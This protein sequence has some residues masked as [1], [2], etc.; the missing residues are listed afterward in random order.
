MHLGPDAYWLVQSIIF[1]L[2]LC[3]QAR[4][5]ERY[6]QVSCFFVAFISGFLFFLLTKIE[7]I[8]DAFLWASASCIYVWPMLYFLLFLYLNCDA[9]NKLKRYFAL[10]CLF[11][12]SSA[13]EPYA[14]LSLTYCLTYY[15]KKKYKEVSNINQFNFLRNC[16][17]IKKKENLSL[18]ICIAGAIFEIFAPG[19]FKRAE[20]MHNVLPSS[21]EDFYNLFYYGVKWCDY[22]LPQVYPWWLLILTIILAITTILLDTINKA[23]LPGEY[24]CLILSW[25]P[26]FV[27]LF[28]PASQSP[29]AIAPIF[30]FIPFIIVP[31]LVKTYQKIGDKLLLVLAISIFV[32]L[33]V[34]YWPIVKG[35]KENYVI[36][37]LNHRILLS[38]PDGDVQQINLFKLRNDLYANCMPY[39]DQWKYIERF[40]KRYYDL[41]MNV[42][43]TYQNYKE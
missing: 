30:I 20:A 16:C 42:S 32:A 21:I 19:N 6:L 41:P 12:A 5:I 33:S 43:F 22:I 39:Y 2:I 26:L 11:L 37:Q 3:L 23:K 35:Y 15:L 8:R 7:L 38:Y 13:S 24:V 27:F 9:S 14:V 28:I 1:T 29:R 18:L 10:F 17:S 34:N 40:I 31:F 25:F 36:H 4:L